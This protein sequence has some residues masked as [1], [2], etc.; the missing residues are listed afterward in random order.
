[1]KSISRPARILVV[2]DE[3]ELER[4]IK[5]R[6]RRQIKDQR[7]FFRF[8][9]SGEEA[10]KLLK[11]EEPIDM[12]LTDINLSE[13]DGLTLLGL[14]PEIDR[15]LK[16]VVVSAYGDLHNIRTAMNQ[17]AFD[18]L[19]KPIDFRDLEATINKTLLSV[20][21]AREAQQQ[22]QQVRDKLAYDALHDL[23]TGLPNR[24]WFMRALDH[25]IQV[26]L[27]HP[28]HLYAVFFMDLD[29][30]K[31]INDSLGHTVGDKVLKGVGARLQK[32]V[33]ATDTVARLGGDEFAVLLDGI[34]DGHE[35]TRIAERILEGLLPPFKFGN[36]EVHSSGSIG[37]VLSVMEYKT[38]E[39][40]LRDADAA[41]YVAKDKGKSCYAIFDPAIQASV[42]ERWQLED[43]LYQAVANQDFK[44]NYQPIVVLSTGLIWGFEILVR[45]YCPDYGWVPPSKFIPIAE[46]TGLLSPIGLWVLQQGCQQLCLWRNQFPNQESIHLNVN[47]SAIQLRQVNLAEQIAQTLQSTGFDAQQLTLEISE[48]WLLGNGESQTQLLKRL[49]ALGVQLCIDDFG[50]G[51]SVLSRLHQ[52]PIDS[53]KIDRTFIEQLDGK[54]ESLEPIKTVMSLAHSRGMNV[55]AEGIETTPQLEQIRTLDCQFAQGYLFSHPVEHQAAGALLKSDRPLK[56]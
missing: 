29:R 7:L 33:R 19:V 30:F 41:M 36:C 35:A 52:F 40:V 6:F 39:E 21:K 15:N 5:Q 49:K 13:M 24:L 32:C 27:R 43:R 8:A 4:L 51:F 44:V 1:M 17:G 47:L 34:Q 55:I 38:P 50:T 18:F 16:A 46:E 37:I 28:N 9:D 10:L 54:P 56:R 20:Q 31:V 23:L 53:V 14:L 3:T 25:S 45:W 22:L 48:S 12:V 2:D 42:M 11:A 26:A